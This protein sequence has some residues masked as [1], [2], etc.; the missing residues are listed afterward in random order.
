MAHYALRVPESLFEYARRVAEEEKVSMNQ[1]FVTAIAE[2]VS[3]LKTESYFRER[4]ARGTDAGFDAWMS[5][6]P[7]VAPD[8]GDELPVS[9]AARTASSN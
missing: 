7:D 2:K 4:M 1:F 5:A 3:A 6:S 8:P 9:A